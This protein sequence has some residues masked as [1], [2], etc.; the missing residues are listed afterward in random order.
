MFIFHDMKG[1]VTK[2]VDSK[3]ATSKLG[4]LPRNLPPTFP[5]QH[6]ISTSFNRKGGEQGNGVSERETSSSGAMNDLDT[7]LAFIS[8]A[9]DMTR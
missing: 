7:A 6:A 5:G 2:L 3:I 8:P 1:P 9:A 4:L